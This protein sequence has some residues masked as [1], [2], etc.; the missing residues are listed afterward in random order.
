MNRWTALPFLFSFSLVSAPLAIAAPEAHLWPKVSTDGATVVA[1]TID[2]PTIT[3]VHIG[4][5]M[6]GQTTYS[7]I[8]IDAGLKDGKFKKKIW[9]RFGAGKYAL[10]IY[11]FHGPASIEGLFELNAENKNTQDILYTTPSDLVESDSPEIEAVA[12]DLKMRF[13]SDPVRLSR[14]IHDWVATN[15]SFDVDFDPNNVPSLSALQTLRRKVAVCNGYSRLNAAIHRAAGLP[16]KTITGKAIHPEL[17]QSWAWLDS[18]PEGAQN[19]FRHAWNEVLLG[20]RWVIEDTTWDSGYVDSS[21]Q[22]TRKLDEKYFDPTVE[23]FG[24]SHKKIKDD[25]N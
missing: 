4:I 20:G 22:F 25:S 11:G 7:A 1:G 18:Q 2:D 19:A 12:N 8:E 5:S 6:P 15:V 17:G 10:R 3:A 13:G 23:F 21:N 14:A 24:L 16:A 9:L